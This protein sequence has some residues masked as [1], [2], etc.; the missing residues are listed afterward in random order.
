ML[1]DAGTARAAEFNTCGHR[2]VTDY[3]QGW[4]RIKDMTGATN[5]PDVRVTGWTGGPHAQWEYVNTTVEAAIYSGLL[6]AAT[7]LSEIYIDNYP[8]CTVQVH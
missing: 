3:N 5:R 4:V 2:V 6:W 7:G 1:S 8:E